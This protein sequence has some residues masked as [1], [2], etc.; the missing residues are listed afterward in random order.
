MNHH[1]R[2][3]GMMPGERVV[4]RM[5][6]SVMLLIPS[7]LGALVILVAAVVALQK[8]AGLGY[9]W[10]PKVILGL[11]VVLLLI[12]VAPAWIT[13]F[14]TIYTVTDR[15]I[16]T[17]RGWLSVHGESVALDR[18]QSIDFSRTILQRIFG[19]GNLIVDSAGLDPLEMAHV[20]GVEALQ[21]GLYELIDALRDS[22]SDEET[23]LK[24]PT[25]QPHRPPYR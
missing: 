22:A 12:V 9:D 20:T 3:A 13:W 7:S 24:Y 19:S 21:R 23:G 1:G 25:G 10:A 8:A 5:R 2:R 16:L 4:R 17:K 18:V 14:T 15:R 11:T 6:Q